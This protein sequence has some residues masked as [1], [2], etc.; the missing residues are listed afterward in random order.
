M[1]CHQLLYLTFVYGF[2]L[3]SFIA[4]SVGRRSCPAGRPTVDICTQGTVHGSETLLVDF[5][6]EAGIN[7][8]NCNLTID[9][10]LVNVTSLV[11]PQSQCGP[12]LEVELGVEYLEVDCN[13]I[14]KSY[15]TSEVRHG[16]IWTTAEVFY[17]GVQPQDLCLEFNV[18]GGAS[19]LS[20][21]CDVER[22]WGPST[23]EAVPLGPATLPS[24]PEAVPTITPATLPP[25]TATA[26]PGTATISQ[27]VT[28][29]TNTK[30]IPVPPDHIRDEIL[31]LAKNDVNPVLF[32]SDKL[33]YNA[34][35]IPVRDTTAV[36]TTTS[37]RIDPDIITSDITSAAVLPPQNIMDKILETA[38]ATSNP[39]HIELQST[40]PLE[41]VTSDDVSTA[42]STVKP[43]E[44]PGIPMVP[45]T[46]IMNQLLH[47]ANN[48]T[49]DTIVF[50]EL[51]VT[52]SH[53]RTTSSSQTQEQT[54]VVDVR[55]TVPPVETSTTPQRQT[56]IIDTHTETTGIPMVP[57]TDIMKQL[58]DIANNVTNDTIVFPELPVTET[59]DRT[60]SSSQTQEHTIVVDVSTTV[61]PVETSTTTPKQRQQTTGV[62]DKT[63]T[64]TTITTTTT[65][66]EPSTIQQRLTPGVI[67]TT[68]TLQHV[69]KSTKITTVAEKTTPKQHLETT[70]AFPTYPSTE[71]D[72]TLYDEVPMESQGDWTNSRTRVVSKA[73]TTLSIKTAPRGD[74]EITTQTDGTK[75]RITDTTQTD[76][77]TTTSSVTD[78]VTG[79]RNS[80]SPDDKNGAEDTL[81]VI[82]VGAIIGII[83]IVAIIAI[84]RAFCKSR[85]KSA[86]ITMMEKGGLENGSGATTGIDNPLVQLQQ[87]QEMVETNPNQANILSGTDQNNGKMEANFSEGATEMNGNGVSNSPQAGDEEIFQSSVNN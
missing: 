38:N 9:G 59:P 87:E 55:T 41:N 36:E 3:M 10:A 14:N 46:D 66:V 40:T 77:E 86:N 35:E 21:T 73:T 18:H 63:T 30:D 65:T 76:V 74:I 31:R 56:A 79:A 7:A 70:T 83:V 42:T 84:I 60:T 1:S 44:T 72:H 28:T 22:D 33:P 24:T 37:A 82:V 49:N 80:T 11:A 19:T 20:I 17:S 48:V 4:G 81:V 47:I 32:E 2:V 23:T 62:D 67:G 13:P 57:P 15:N 25:S 12:Q 43:T 51:P 27:N 71:Y 5:S 45:P 52:E 6:P 85:H 69:A 54:K 64:T 29:D 8:C 78:D 39:I 53:D 26:G 58:I 61:L 75:T 34:T 50:P 16:I 68:S